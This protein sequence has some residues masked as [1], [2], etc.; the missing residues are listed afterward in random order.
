MLRDLDVQ[1]PRNA[2]VCGETERRKHVHLSASHRVEVNIVN[3]KPGRN[4]EYFMLKFEGA[5]AAKFEANRSARVVLSIHCQ[6]Q[7]C[8]VQENFIRCRDGVV[9]FVFFQAQ[10]CR[11][12]NREK[13]VHVGANAAEHRRHLVQSACRYALH[14]FRCTHAACM[15]FDLCNPGVNLR[16]CHKPGSRRLS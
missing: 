1:S 6:H 10:G 12:L 16:Q 14:S 2:I 5:S 9:S 13:D 7:V 4:L 8:G 3:R 11:Q 15:Y